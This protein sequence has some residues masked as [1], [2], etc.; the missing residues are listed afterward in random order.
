MQEVQHSFGQTEAIFGFTQESTS[1]ITSQPDDG[2]GGGSDDVDCDAP[3][4]EI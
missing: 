3:E 2:D 4:S 1:D